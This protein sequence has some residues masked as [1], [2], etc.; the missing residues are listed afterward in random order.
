MYKAPCRDGNVERSSVGHQTAALTFL[1]STA[2]EKSEIHPATK[3][4]LSVA[5]ASINNSFHKISSR[6]IRPRRHSFSSENITASVNLQIIDIQSD[7]IFKPV[8]E[9][10]QRPA[11]CGRR[12]AWCACIPPLHL[13]HMPGRLSQYRLAKG[14]YEE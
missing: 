13:Q 1:G 14:P 12:G 11:L 2:E 4:F 8:H 3:I 10:G 7:L 9:N 5:T 6:H